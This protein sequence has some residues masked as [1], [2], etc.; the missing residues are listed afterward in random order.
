[1]G[2]KVL[3]LV[4]F[5]LIINS[6]FALNYNQIKKAY[7]NSFRFEVLGKY[8]EAI[9]ALSLVYKE[10]P[11]GY[12]VNLRL[13]WLYYLMK[14]YKNSLFHYEK[15]I[16][17]LPYSVE[18]KLGYTLPLLAQGRYEDVEKVC[19][20][21]LNIDFYNYY[22]NLRLIYALR[23]QKKFDLAEKVCN[24]ML[25]IYPTDI[26]FLTQLLRIKIEANKKEEA[27]KLA[28]DILII[29]PNNETAIDVLKKEE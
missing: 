4:Y 25:Y 1:M 8:K 13:G 22:G 3:I 5:F 29:S 21:I 6:S 15:A 17:A 28:K 16:K 26:E 12:T 18:A 23:K 20:Q 24:K 14:K 10:Y 9:E 11:D 7:E 2:K 19:Y 27:K